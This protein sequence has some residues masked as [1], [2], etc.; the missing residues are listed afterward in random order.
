MFPEKKDG[1]V[2]FGIGT[3]LAIMPFAPV[4][5]A[6]AAI[7]GI[8]GGRLLDPIIPVIPVSEY[9]GTTHENNMVGNIQPPMDDTPKKVRK[10]RKPRTK[11]G[12]IDVGNG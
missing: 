10:P 9:P 6:M 5:T 1:Y 2:G 7:A 3:I 4:F 11:K 8:I 12:N